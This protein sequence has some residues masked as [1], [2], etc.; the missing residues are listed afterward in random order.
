MVYRVMAYILLA[1]GCAAWSA[2]GTADTGDFAVTVDYSLSEQNTPAVAVGPHGVFGIVWAD[3]RNGQ[4]DIYYQAYDSG[5]IAIGDNN[6]LSDDPNGEMQLDPDLACDWRGVYHAVWTDYRNA[7]YPF[8][9][10]IYYQRFDTA[11]PIGGNV[12]VSDELPDS[13]RQSP[14]IG[15]AGWGTSVVTWTDLRNR[16]WDI[17]ARMLDSTGAVATDGVRVNDDIGSAPQH[18]PAAAVAPGG[19]YVVAWYDN[20]TGNDDIYLQK[21]DSSGTPLGGNVLVNTDAGTAKQKFPDIAVGGDGII[22]VVWTDWRNGSYPDNSDIYCQRFN[23][24]LE[25]LGANRMVNSAAE[26]CRRDPRV[27]VD[28]AGNACV[29][30]SDSSAGDWNARGQMI[31]NDGRM[32]GTNFAVNLDLPNRQLRPDVALDGYNAYFAWADHRNGNFDIYG[33]IWQYNVPGLTA[34]PSRIEISRDISEATW[35]TIPVVIANAGFGE[36][37]FTTFAVDD[38]LD[39]S[40]S[41]GHTPESLMVYIHSGALDHGLHQGT[42]KLIDTQHQDSTARITVLVTITGP[43]IEIAADTLRFPAVIEAGSPPDQYVRIDNA[44]TGVL[45]WRL[46]TTTTWLTLGAIAG[47][48]GESVAV[49][50]DIAGLSAGT[51]DGAVV[52]SDSN[53]V[54]SPETLFVQCVLQSDL[55]FLKAEPER[56]ASSCYPSE[57][58]IDSIRVVN[59]G[60]GTIE[61]T[62]ENTS[63]W[64]TLTSSSGV[65]NDYIAYAISGGGLTAGSYDDTVTIRDT[66]AFNDPLSVPVELTVLAADTVGAMPVTVERGAMFHQAFY[67]KT[68]NSL[69]SATLEFA[70]EPQMISIDSFAVSAAAD[71]TMAIAFQNDAGT[72]RFLLQIDAD[73]VKSIIPPAQYYLGELWGSANDSLT[74]TATTTMIAENSS[75]SLTDYGDHVPV[76]TGGDVEISLPT[77]VDDSPGPEPSLIYTLEQNRPNPFN[78]VTT[79]SYSTEHSG[80]VHLVV[81]NILGQLVRTLVD[82][83]QGAG[84]HTVVW[85]G[86]DSSGRDMASGIFF[87][88]LRTADFSAVRKMVYLK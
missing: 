76:W 84:P 45:N 79:I 33:R 49:G 77:A 34:E 41:S 10:D 80:P 46:T 29:V 58:Q 2:A 75:L 3:Y 26:G 39:V 55:P 70:C 8:K 65:D 66:A 50:C 7:A 23:A 88:K 51:Y 25:R 4:G 73:A 28:D 31:D 1:F 38:W 22:H 60:S 12:F 36:L 69:N 42:I 44:G 32:S 64:M 71:S 35:D 30:W 48:G 24:A 15:C 82:D 74:G 87:Y 11:G 54:N 57:S 16:N 20:R 62:A 13:S 52:V 5:G 61:W 85:D 40:Q 78:G 63:G 6:I 37:D 81:Y 59:A 68:N 43:V 53:A 72:G 27:A 56:I 67:L 17:F 86:R 21:Y 18:E 9:P 47:V 83:N 19:W 14:A